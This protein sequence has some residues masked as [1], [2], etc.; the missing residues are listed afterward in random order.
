MP[1]V[2]QKNTAIIMVCTC[3]KHS[4]SPGDGV[5][6]FNFRDEK[7]YFHCECGK[8]NVLDFSFTKPAPFPSMRVAR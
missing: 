3:G 7:I 1:D 8:M 4:N 5:I 2:I 6:E